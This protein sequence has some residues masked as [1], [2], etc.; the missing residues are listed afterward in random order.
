MFELPSQ[1]RFD[2]TQFLGA[3]TIFDQSEDEFRGDDPRSPAWR[4][5]RQS[6]RLP[7][8]L[9]AACIQALSGTHHGGGK[10]A[11]H[12]V[13]LVEDAFG[14]KKGRLMSFIK[15][16][17]TAAAS[18]FT[19]MSLGCAGALADGPDDARRI[20][21]EVMA[22]APIPA[23]SVAVVTAGGEHYAAAFG[24]ASIELDAAAG[25][26]HRFRLGSVSKVITASLTARLADQGV[27]D[28][29]A[30]ISEYRPD[31]PDAHA[32]TTLRQL[33]GHQGGVRHYAAQDYDPSAPGS[34][35]DLR[36]Y[37]TTQSM[38]DLFIDDPLVAE[39]GASYAYST[40]G[41]TL[42]GA[43]LEAAT[44]QSFIQLVERE[45]AGPLGLDSLEDDH[46]FT[47]RAGRVSYYDSAAVYRAQLDP[48]IEGEVVNAL[49]N[50]PAYK[51]P[52]GGLVATAE[53]LARFGA[54]HF[55]PGFLTAHFTQTFTPQSTAGGEMTPVGLGW[56][57]DH[58]EAGRLRYHHAGSQQGARAVLV[59][60]PED[61]VSVALMGNLGGQPEDIL[62]P[63][64]EIAAA[65]ME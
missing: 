44:G 11:A 7:S 12:L 45:I 29:D 1:E 30:P 33:L 17:L 26:H 42:V 32:Q 35:I 20:V 21:G 55:E 34:I 28:L 18:A 49:R 22:S 25:P 31:L 19:I 60:Y 56:R 65:F 47:V 59:V 3:L 13:A 6:R 27:V 23:M 2:S 36:A 39:P 5:S 37:P 16:H 15:M 51:T 14:G 8:I 48:T 54:A 58:D 4:H 40:F 53:D 46:L 63:A 57:V 43:V 52:G 61:G 64:A 62:T 9:L 24:R 38:L 10:R 50:N 41:Y